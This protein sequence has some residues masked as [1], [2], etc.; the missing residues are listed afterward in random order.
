MEW[1]QEELSLW[2]LYADTPTIPSLPRDAWIGP[3]TCR[4]LTFDNSKESAEKS[5]QE[6]T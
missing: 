1:L 5:Q 6:A 4:R 3:A 2:S